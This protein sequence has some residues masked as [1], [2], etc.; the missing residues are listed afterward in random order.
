MNCS[1][2]DDEL[3]DSTEEIGYVPHVKNIPRKKKN[4]KALTPGP[5]QTGPGPRAGAASSSDDEPFR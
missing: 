3:L 2:S 4:G 1:I 5:S